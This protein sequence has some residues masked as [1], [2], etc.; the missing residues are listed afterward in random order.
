M[1]PQP[2][3]LLSAARK[4]LAANVLEERQKVASTELQPLLLALSVESLAEAIRE[5]PDTVCIGVEQWRQ[6]GK[7]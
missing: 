2:E 1:A 7:A 6:H 3:A 4:Y 5:R